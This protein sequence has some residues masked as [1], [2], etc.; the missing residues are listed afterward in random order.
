MHT[1]ASAHSRKVIPLTV[2]KGRWIA[3]EVAVCSP[4]QWCAAKHP[5]A[6]AL[7]ATEKI[8]EDPHQYA[9]YVAPSRLMSSIILLEV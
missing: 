1:Q 4:C 9:A 7:Q 8:M 3:R 2:H 6:V 5:D